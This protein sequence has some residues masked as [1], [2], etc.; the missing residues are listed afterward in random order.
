MTAKPKASIKKTPVKASDKNTLAIK[1]DNEKSKERR[2]AEM[3][4][5]TN[6]LNTATA[7]SFTK[8]IVGEIDVGEALAV[9]KEKVS[10]VKAGDLSG[11]EATLT[12]QVTSLDTVFNALA[13][14]ANS[15][16]TMTKLEI[17]MR[18]ALKAQA[19]CARTIEVLAAMKN[20]P[21][22]FAKQANITNGNQQINNGSVQNNKVTDK[23]THAGKTINQSNE[24][25]EH[26]HH[27]EWL[28][29]GKKATTSGADQAMAA[30]ETLNRGE[31][32]TG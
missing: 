10:K 22:V 11:L 19:Q 21:I 2:L 29:N 15:S 32:A 20:P 9:M 3:G 24:L 18:L 4:L 30:V 13:S 17:Y 26:Q 6:I 12:A 27:G 23:P 16:D 28:D 8:G 31:N 7:S 25:L 14:R 5:S 1:N